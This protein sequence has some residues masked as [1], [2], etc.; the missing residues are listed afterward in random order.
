MLSGEIALKNNHYY[1]TAESTEA[2]RK[3]S[4]AQEHKILVLSQ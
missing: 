4:L 1:F 3:K 2:T